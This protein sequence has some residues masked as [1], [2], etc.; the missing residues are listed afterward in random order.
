VLLRPHERLTGFPGFFEID[1]VTHIERTDLQSAVDHFGVKQPVAIGTEKGM[2]V[3]SLPA[4][5]V[6]RHGSQRFDLRLSGG[7]MDREE[8]MG[9]PV[10]FEKQELVAGSRPVCT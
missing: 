3:E 6:A 7:K 4:L 9:F 10:V 8:P 2:G 5:R 1:K